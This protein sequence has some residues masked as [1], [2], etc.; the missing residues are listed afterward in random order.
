M[1]FNDCCLTWKESILTLVG[2]AL[3]VKVPNFS[4]YVYLL[5]GGLLGVKV[6]CGCRGCAPTPD[7]LPVVLPFAFLDL[8]LVRAGSDACTVNFSPFFDAAHFF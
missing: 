8:D 6:P 1:C 4:R 2:C 7:G 5:L 3:L